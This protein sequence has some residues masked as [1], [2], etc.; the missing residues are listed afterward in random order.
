MEARPQHTRVDLRRAFAQVAVDGAGGQERTFTYSVPGEMDVE[1]GHLVWVPFGA[2]TV[3]GIVFDITDTPEV[4]ETRDIER[5]AHE[6][7]LLS[8]RQIRVARWMSAYYRVGLFLAAV[9]MLPPGFAS[10]LRTWVSLD[11]ERANDPEVTGDLGPRDERALR[12]VEDAV[13]LRRPALARRLGRGGGAVVD[14]LIRRKLLVTRT[15]WERQRQKPRYARVL[16]LAVEAD[17][18]EKV[19]EELD[20][21]P[22]TRGI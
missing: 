7:P 6:R 18:V 21:G 15:E 1:P 5:V 3:Q 9:Q 14:R 16:S 22:G 13:E 11:T 19:A 8:A 20:A 2:R 10:R 17:E 12:M 4:E